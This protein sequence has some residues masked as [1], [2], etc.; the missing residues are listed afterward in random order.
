MKILHNDLAV[1]QETSRFVRDTVDKI[2]LDDNFYCCTSSEFEIWHIGD[3][4][5][6]QSY[7]CGGDEGNGQ[8]QKVFCGDFWEQSKILDITMRGNDFLSILKSRGAA[9]CVIETRD[10]HFVW[11]HDNRIYNLAIPEHFKAEMVFVA[12]ARKLY[13]RPPVFHVF[14]N[15]QALA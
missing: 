4:C 11:G 12:K 5:N 10:A 8:G 2:Y 9:S 14:T 6:R 15:T 7:R 3:C 1:S 13:S